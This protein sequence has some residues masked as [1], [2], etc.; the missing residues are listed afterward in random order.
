MGKMRSKEYMKGRMEIVLNI[1]L[2]I[3]YLIL[4]KMLF[5]KVL[6]RGV[7]YKFNIERLI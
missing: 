5:Y 1:K 2:I 3:L 7:K 6:S 4:L